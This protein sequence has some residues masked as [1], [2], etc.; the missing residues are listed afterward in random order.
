M[1]G[2]LTQG[3][4]TPTF[5]VDTRTQHRASVAVFSSDVSGSSRVEHDSRST[6]NAQGASWCDSGDRGRVREEE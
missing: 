4:M 2:G 6:H 1:N 5:R 3:E